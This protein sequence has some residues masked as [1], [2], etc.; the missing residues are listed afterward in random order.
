MNDL[1]LC[2]LKVLHSE[3][4]SIEPPHSELVTLGASL[5]PTAPEDRVRQLKEELE[6]LQMRLCVQNE[7][8][9]QRYR[10]MK[11]IILAHEYNICPLDL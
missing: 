2:T 3:V 11:I 4:Q 5:Y 10:E 8:L 9:P 1:L 6:T 7:V